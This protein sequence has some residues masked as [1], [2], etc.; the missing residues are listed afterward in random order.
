MSKCDTVS[1]SNTFLSN[2]LPD[3]L[4]FIGIKGSGMAALALLLH[5]RG[6]SISGSDIADEFYTDSLLHAENIPICTGFSRHNIP[7]NTKA[8]IYSAAYNSNNNEELAY[9]LQ[10]YPCYSYPESL[11]AFSQRV[12]S[13]WAVI[14]THGKTSTS[15]LV[16][17]LLRSQSCLA[18]VLTGARVKE[19]NNSTFFSDGDEVF[20]A[21][22]CEYRDHFLHF[23]ATGVIFLNAEWDH[24]D[25]F[26]DK[27]AVYNS[28]AT[29][30]ETLPYNG[31][32]IACMSDRGVQCTLEKVVKKRND[33]RII[34]Y[35]FNGEQQKEENTHICMSYL[36]DT[37][38]V[39]MHHYKRDIVAKNRVQS[40]QLAVSVSK[41]TK[42]EYQNDIV[43]YGNVQSLCDRTWNMQ[44]PVYPLVGNAMAALLCIPYC[45]PHVN[46]DSLYDAL[47]HFS[48]VSRRAELLYKKNG[49]YIVDDYAHHPTAV[50]ATLQ[51][52][53]DH[54]TPRRCI[55]DFMSHTYTRTQS[56][57]N[58]FQTCFQKADILII[59][60]IYSSAREREEY[61]NKAQKD[62]SMPVISGETLAR[63]IGEYQRGVMSIPSFEES[64]GYI[65]SIIQEGD[66]CITMGA[67]DNF[68]V[69]TMLIDIL[70]QREV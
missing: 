48:S 25:Y 58:E 16:G 37:P 44:N 19:F 34:P 51:S 43:Q 20:I 3:A 21:E 45:V 13:S 67:G 12:K 26:K 60:D 50:A 15:A 17:V 2:T 54:Y 52:L 41:D 29:F 68:R 18:T 32:V 7:S 30:I 35:A 42:K 27:E 39:T 70:K 40:F 1:S 69:A 47:L 65:S 10:Q 22:V 61:Y 49:I 36:E 24:T 66:L 4:H 38:I 31:T 46:S 28:F 63:H 14:G 55:V 64:A 9:A 57:W 59:N 8:V 5:K 62:V 23:R 6:V 33:L 56:L 11:G 53:V